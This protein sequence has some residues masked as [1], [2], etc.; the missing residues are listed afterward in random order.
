MAKTSGLHCYHRPNRKTARRFSAKDAGRVARY[1]LESGESC[2][3]V[4]FEIEKSLTESGCPPENCDCVLITEEVLAA[5]AAIAAIATVL[6]SRGKANKLAAEETAAL[7]ERLRKASGQT[8]TGQIK[9]LEQLKG[10]FEMNASQDDEIAAGLNNLLDRM[11]R[12]VQ[13]E[14]TVDAGQITITP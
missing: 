5:V 7:I 3:D 9:V 14:A 1:A 10:L 12:S 13:A 4:R 6:I 2:T 8:P 11:Q